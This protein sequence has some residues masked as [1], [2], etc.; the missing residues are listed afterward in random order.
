MS[1][2]SVAAAHERSDSHL[3]GGCSPG[4]FLYGHLSGLNTKPGINFQCPRVLYVHLPCSHT[5]VL[6]SLKWKPA[7]GRSHGR[8]PEHF[9]AVLKVYPCKMAH[10]PTGHFCG[11]L[12]LTAAL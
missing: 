6:E 2:A 10:L 8:M 3:S 9:P 4:H 1:A 5:C 11:S 12:S 7:G